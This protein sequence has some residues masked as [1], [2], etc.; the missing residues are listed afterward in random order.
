M[1]QTGIGWDRKTELVF[2]GVIV[3]ATAVNVIVAFC[4]WSAITESN[5]LNSRPYIKIISKPEAFVIHTSGDPK[6]D[7]RGIKFRLENTGKMPGLTWVRSS[8][9]WNGTGHAAEDRD[10]PSIGL[11][12]RKF[13]FTGTDDQD[14]PTYEIGLTPAQTAD[15]KTG[16]HF[17]VLIDAVY[18]PS[19]DVYGHGPSEDYRTKVCTAYQIK[20]ADTLITLGDGEPCPSDGSNFA[21]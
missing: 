10:W 9:N 8:A 14:F 3:L 20:R 4:Q 12:A 1:S 17:Y 5:R 15:I 6:G 18:G 19:K 13:V 16:D 2:A 7:F 11:V 21:R